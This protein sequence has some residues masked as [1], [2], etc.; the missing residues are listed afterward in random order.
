[1]AQTFDFDIGN[2]VGPPGATGNGIKSIALLSTSGL[3]KTYRITM[4]DDT[5]F[6]FSVSDGEDGNGISGASF[7]AETNA[8][9]ITFDDGSTFTTP[10][11]KGD[12]GSPGTPGDDGYS[13]A[14]TIET[15]TGGHRV[16]ITDEAH[17]AGQSFD[18]LDGN[19]YNS[20]PIIL[21]SASGD[22]ATFADGAD[23]RQIRKIVGTIVPVQ[24]GTGDPSPDNVRP[25]SGWTGCNITRAGKNLVDLNESNIT[26]I[27]SAFPSDFVCENGEYSG[28]V[29]AG[30]DYAIAGYNILLR[31]G[32]YSISFDYVNGSGNTAWKG[33]LLVPATASS[34]YASDKMQTA[35]ASAS[36]HI[37]KT[38]TLTENHKLVLTLNCFGTLSSSAKNIISNLQI[39]VGT[40]ESAYVD[41]SDITT[42][43]INWQT[44]AGTIYGGTVT[45]NEDGSAD[46]VADCANYH[47]LPSAW[48]YQ[49]SV[50]AWFIARVNLSPLYSESNSGYDGFYGACDCYPFVR[51]TNLVNQQLNNTI[52]VRN[53]T[54]KAIYCRTDGTSDTKPVETNIVLKVAEPV[55]YHF[56]NIGQLHTF[57]GTNNVWIDTGAI[58]ECDYPADTKTY[59]DGKGGAVSDVQI[60]GTSILEDGVANIPVAS[61]N[62]SG[63]VSVS[64]VYGLTSADGLLKVSSSTVNQI[65]NGVGMFKPIVPNYQQYATFYGLAKAAGDT[66]QSA[67]ANAV[68]AYTEDAKSAIHEMLNGA[69]TV[70][71]TTPTIV[72]K[73]GITYVCGEVATL[74]IT[75]PASG[76]FDVIFTSGSTPTV[77]TVTGVTWMNGFDPTVLEANKTYEVNILN[78]LGVASWT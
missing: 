9:T 41:A 33:V 71:G 3:V 49:A 34:W 10:S 39:E 59:V 11:L 70:S 64:E 66:T 22:I 75:P 63:V 69:V 5:T 15:I 35:L 53:D 50:N 51:Y 12:P 56:D 24:S 31:P 27:S 45:L 29:P 58:T 60:D 74:D 52:A 44:E 2:V 68:G 62:T 21:N 78:G 48:A 57:L 36:G 4:T 37:S 13:P 14:V 73:S 30:R 25:I 55:T 67:S 76:I 32:T 16:T 46:V 6:D 26:R 61:Q 23:N 54:V 7:D 72:A 8:L 65:K 19:E 42:L 43:P 77:L 20:A 40:T 18:V 17:P 1:M 28:T 38:I 47:I